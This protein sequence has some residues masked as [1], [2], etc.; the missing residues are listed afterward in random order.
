M[1]KCSFKV[2]DYSLGKTLKSGQLFRWRELASSKGVSYLVQSKDKYCYIRQPAEDFIELDYNLNDVDYWKN[3]FSLEESM[4]SWLKDMMLEN[5][6]LREVYEFSVGIRLLKQDPWECLICFII[7]QQKRI[8]QIMYCVERLCLN[9]GRH[10]CDDLYAF[11]TL[12]QLYN[13]DLSDIG[14]GYRQEYIEGVTSMFES[15]VIRLEDFDRSVC[16]YYE[17]VAGLK[18]IYGVGS[19]I[20]NCVALFSLGHTNAFPIDIHI[21]RVLSL[22][23]MSNFDPRSLGDYAGLVQQLI[24]YYALNNNYKGHLL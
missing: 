19:K 6:F 23:E 9:F 14:L 5:E 13:A 1:G 4:P 21:K 16:S 22:P 7:S 17:C 15:E 24:F 8:E 18:G 12:M 3:F 10:L 20:A 2:S 11:P